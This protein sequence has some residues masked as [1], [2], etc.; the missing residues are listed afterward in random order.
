MKSKKVYQR[1]EEVEGLNVEYFVVNGSES[2]GIGI[3]EISGDD[4]ID[5]DIV[6]DVFPTQ[7]IAEDFAATLANHKVLAISLR[8]IV[9]DYFVEKIQFTDNNI[10]L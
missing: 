1:T 10:T 6:C 3:C 2:Y 7:S 4:T 9:R 8:D 5:Q